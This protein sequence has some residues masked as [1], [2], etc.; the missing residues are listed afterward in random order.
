M[1]K[2]Y[3]VVVHR[4]RLDTIETKEHTYQVVGDDL[5]HAVFKAGQV[6]HNDQWN[7][8]YFYVSGASY[9]SDESYEWSAK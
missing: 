5:T 3:D 2:I 9:W 7:I 4:Q 6:Y 1:G 8:L